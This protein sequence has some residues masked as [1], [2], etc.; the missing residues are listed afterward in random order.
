MP[1]V[2]SHALCGLQ[3]LQEVGAVV[4][5]SE[6]EVLNIHS[7][8]RPHELACMHCPTDVSSREQQCRPSPV[9]LANNM[10]GV[11]LCEYRV[12]L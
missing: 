12:K 1:F 10:P 3:L 6:A 7:G 5:R 4:W 9:Q 8:T 11:L 2:A